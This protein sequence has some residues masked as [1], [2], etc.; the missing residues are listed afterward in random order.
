MQVKFLWVGKTKSPVL[1]SLLW[2]YVER[3][4]RLVP[5][6]VIETRDLSK[7]QSLR[8]ADLIEA[9]GEELARHLP[10]NGRLVA[11]DETGSQF[12]SRDFAQWFESEQNRGARVLTFVIGGPEGLSRKISGKA[13]LV[14]SLGKMTW[15]HEMCRILL[16]EQIYRALCILRNIPYHKDSN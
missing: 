9:E 4:R 6:E 5:C 12:T 2:D 1:K 11:L 8:P 7:R 14:L 3:I 13:N 15:T 16:A 10:E